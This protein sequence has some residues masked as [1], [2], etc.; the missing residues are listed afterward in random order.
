MRCFARLMRCAMVAS[1][2]RKA[3]AISAVDRPPTARRVSAT[4]DG[5]VSAGWQHRNSSVRVSSPVGPRASRSGYASPPAGGGGGGAAPPPPRGAGAPGRRGGRGGGRPPPPAGGGRRRGAAGRR[6]AAPP[7]S[8]PPLGVSPAP[9]ARATGPWPPPAPPGRRPRRRRSGRSGAPAHRAPPGPAAGRPASRSRPDVGLV[10]DRPDLDA[11][12]ARRR[13]ASRDLQGP[14][15]AV[16][17]DDPQAAQVLLGLGVGAV[18][19]HGRP[20]G[21]PDHLGVHLVGQAIGADELARLEQLLVEGIGLAD[22]LGEG[23]RTHRAEG[24]LVAVDQQHVL[25]GSLLSYCGWAG[26]TRSP[27]A[28]RSSSTSFDRPVTV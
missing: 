17:V 23:L 28:P 5:G 14:F 20:A 10:H 12:V 16:A 4:C 22:D 3:R 9:P 26:P 18:G 7:P 15:L 1:G 8:P 6:G 2:T 13:V 21:D 11:P 27:L 25:H 19:H 24:F